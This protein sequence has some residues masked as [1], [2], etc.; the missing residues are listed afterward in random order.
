VLRRN[1]RTSWPPLCCFSDDDSVARTGPY[2]ELSSGSFTAGRI[3]NHV[4]Y[5]GGMTEP[6]LQVVRKEI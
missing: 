5:L 1:H 4:D 3:A 2:A 6:W